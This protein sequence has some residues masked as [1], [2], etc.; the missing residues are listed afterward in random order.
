[1][2]LWNAETG[3][4]LATLADSMAKEIEFRP[5]SS[6]LLLSYDD[7]TVELWAMANLEEPL[8]SWESEVKFLR[9]SRDGAN[10]AAALPTGEL[11]IWTHQDQEPAVLTR[12]SWSR[13]TSVAFLE[14][15]GE[16]AA[17]FED[18][19]ILVSRQRRFAADDKHAGH[20]EH[21][22]HLAYSPDG[23][24]LL[25]VCEDDCLR[26]FDVAKGE[27][28]DLIQM[29]GIAKAEFDG[30][31]RRIFASIAAPPESGG[32]QGGVAVFEQAEEGGAFREGERVEFTGPIRD[33]ALTPDGQGLIVLFNTVV[34]Y[35]SSDLRDEFALERVGASCV[36]I[37]P[38]GAHACF[39]T[40]AGLRLWN[41]A[42]LELVDA[43]DPTGEN[44][45][46]IAYTPDGASIVAGYGSGAV[47]MWSRDGVTLRQTFGP[48][49]RARV[50]AVA[51]SAAGQLLATSSADGTVKIW[52]LAAPEAESYAIEI[53]QQPVSAVDFGP[54]GTMLAE[55]GEDQLVRLWELVPIAE[56]DAWKP[57]FSGYVQRGWFAM[58][59]GLLFSQ[60]T[61]DHLTKMRRFELQNA[62]EASVWASGPQS[63]GRRAFGRCLTEH[64][65]AKALAQLP[66]LPEAEREPVAKAVG[67]LRKL[68]AK[69]ELRG[70]E[71]WRL[72]EMSQRRTVDLAE[73]FEAINDL[74]AESGQSENERLFAIAAFLSEKGFILPGVLDKLDPDAELLAGSAD[75][76]A[77]KLGYTDEERKNYEALQSARQAMFAK[78]GQAAY[79]M[80]IN[81]EI[82]G[83]AYYEKVFKSAPMWPGYSS[84]I[85]IGFGFDLGY[86]SDE[87]FARFWQEHLPA[88]HFERLKTAVGFKT[89][90][91]GRDAKVA[92]AKEL[93]ESF[94]DIKIPWD[95]AET[96]FANSTLP[97]QYENTLRYL[98]TLEELPPDCRGSLVSLVLNR[99]GSF[100]RSGQRYSEMKAI[101]DAMA[102]G[103]FR[104]IPAQFRSMKRLWTTSG[105]QKRRDDEADI[106]EMGLEQLDAPT[107]LAGN[108]S[109]DDVTWP[110]D[111]DSPFYRH[112]DYDRAQPDFALTA[113]DLELLIAANRFQ[114][115]E[116]K[117]DVLFALR[118]CRLQGGEAK[119]RAAAVNLTDARPDHRTLQCV[120]GVLHRPDGL[121]SAFSGSTVPNADYVWRYFETQTSGN[122]LATGCYKY[123][124]AAHSMNRFPGCFR[125]GEI[126]AALRSPNDLRYDTKDR[127][128]VGQFFDNITPGFSRPDGFEFISAGSVTLPGSYDRESGE[129]SGHFGEFRQAA[130]L[131]PG[132]ES[133]GEKFSLV[134]L[135][136]AEALIASRLRQAHGDIDAAHPEV[137]QK[138]ARLRHG[139]EGEDAAML[140][141]KLELEGDRLEAA[142]IE[143]LTKL[144]TE[145]LDWADGIFSREMD[146]L[147]KLGVYQPEEPQS[148][149]PPPAPDPDVPP[150]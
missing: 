35:L 91:P 73:A 136:G 141:E 108:D 135:T 89:T 80:I 137:R 55:G 129:Y 32:K 144:Q 49:H 54:A 21:V 51:V 45:S 121:I 142:A 148:P 140:L 7:G 50:T 92:R 72:R 26:I 57:D 145:K 75:K 10:L 18:G 146:R 150:Q 58:E 23:S 83:R 88:E 122:I 63:F 67:V 95:V 126:V 76:V 28:V 96:V 131:K 64:D 100:G 78:I 44:V 59:N 120:A 74:N 106:F 12:E 19:R 115:A 68:A 97:A 112:L 138:L 87:D 5:D 4:E 13:A 60:T 118:G 27:R 90:E 81:Y 103:N 94:A 123:E 8:S 38:S 128:H 1:M 9:F 66:R 117:G 24:R 43:K 127:W 33:F 147:L 20:T 143:A 111:E 149:P 134:L 29:P 101:G 110:E 113:A 62:S 3:G 104:S 114:P 30:T 6:Q 99:G 109:A 133:H 39:G 53:S 15:N 56:K 37:D 86:Y 77:E 130:G 42:D 46:A 16:I 132:T 11:Q 85:T 93:V 47:K 61:S 125:Q 71:A 105:L 48:A 82:G 52:D 31:G 65:W 2:K 119:N 70:P 116:H 34:L 84:G 25:T 124:V 98:P 69:A 41:L 14:A 36:A 79:E 40:R 139:S 22:I 17:G 102:S 107:Q